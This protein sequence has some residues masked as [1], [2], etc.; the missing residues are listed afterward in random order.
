MKYDWYEYVSRD[1]PKDEWAKKECACGFIAVMAYQALTE[2]T[3]E[4]AFNAI[5]ASNE[6]CDI[7]GTEDLLTSL[8]KR[9]T[10]LEQAHIKE[11]K[12][13]GLTAES[14][15]RFNLPTYR[16]WKLLIGE[17]KKEWLDLFEESC[18]PKFE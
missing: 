18:A 14:R 8:K 1:L 11:Y 3:L 9:E 16:L 5:T 6:A 2:G 15:E 10:T 12:E 13:A 4:D 17:A 7:P